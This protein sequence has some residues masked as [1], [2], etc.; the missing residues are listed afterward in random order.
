ML[1][2]EISFLKVKES[3]AGLLMSLEI[4]HYFSTKTEPKER[5]HQEEK[6]DE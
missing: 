1:E 6:K 2:R 3:S 5:K 4:G